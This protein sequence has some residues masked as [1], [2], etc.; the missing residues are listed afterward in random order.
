MLKSLRKHSFLIEDVEEGQDRLLTRKQ[1]LA[2]VPISYP[3][4]WKLMCQG[5][6][7]RPRKVGSRSLWSEREILVLIPAQP[8]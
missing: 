5:K 2:L 4:I 3:T 1:V 7:P 8:R 6:F